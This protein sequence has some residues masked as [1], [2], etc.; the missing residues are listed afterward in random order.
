MPKGLLC[1]EPQFS[2]FVKRG[3]VGTIWI[4]ASHPG[5]HT[6]HVPVPAPGAGPAPD[7]LSEGPHRPSW[8]NALIGSVQ[9]GETWFQ[10]QPRL[11]FFLTF[12]LHGAV[13][14][15]RR[16]NQHPKCREGSGGQAPGGRG[17]AGESAKIPQPLPE[18]LYLSRPHKSHGWL[19]SIY[20]LEATGHMGW[21]QI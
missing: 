18:P 1:F 15:A 4:D 10:R 20:S 7:P 5:V 16:S 11:P 12:S 14:S 21:F 6:S 19:L 13:S 8:E 3:Q 17:E 9:F 2:S